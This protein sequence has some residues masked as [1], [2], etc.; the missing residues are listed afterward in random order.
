MGQR[1]H[2]TKARV[3][4]EVFNEV[5][6]MGVIYHMI[7]YSDF[8]LNLDLAFMLGYTHIGLIGLLM[9]VNIANMA[10][11]QVNR[12]LRAKRLKVKKQAKLN[13]KVVVRSLRERVRA[14]RLEVMK[15]RAD[16]NET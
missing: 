6:V 3:R 5:I 8:N 7:M 13:E 10:R 11:N 12:Y 2:N 15:Q 9:A 16:Q 1:P 4:L 14:K